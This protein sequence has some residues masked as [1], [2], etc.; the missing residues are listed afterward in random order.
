MR[1]ERLMVFLKKTYE[2]EQNVFEFDLS[3]QTLTKVGQNCSLAQHRNEKA[4]EQ[5]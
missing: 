1:W 3:I 4:L 5:F 2:T